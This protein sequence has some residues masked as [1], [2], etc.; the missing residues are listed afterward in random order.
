MSCHSGGKGGGA[1]KCHVLIEWPQTTKLYWITL[2]IWNTTKEN[3]CFF[4]R[5]F[6]WRHNWKSER[7]WT[8]HSIWNWNTGLHWKHFGSEWTLSLLGSISA[9]IPVLK[10]NT[11][12]NRT[13]GWI[14]AWMSGFPDEHSRTGRNDCE[15]SITFCQILCDSFS[16]ATENISKFYA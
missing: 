2:K 4:S 16:N 7:W 5:T 6:Y 14:C 10:S 11:R 15:S 9:K 13:S 8:V 1:K 12:R 3:I